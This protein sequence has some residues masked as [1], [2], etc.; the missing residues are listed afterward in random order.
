MGQ[1]ERVA[2]GNHGLPDHEIVGVTHPGGG[3]DL[4]CIEPKD[5]KI[6]SGIGAQDFG[7]VFSGVRSD[8]L[9][10]SGSGHHVMVCDDISALSIDDDPGT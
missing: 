9:D 8:H 7:H 3:K 6:G 4:L 1:T 10:F 2:Y 5:G